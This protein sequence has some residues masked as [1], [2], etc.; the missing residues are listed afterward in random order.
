[1]S[2]DTSNTHPPWLKAMQNG[3]IG[4]ARAKAFLLDRFWVLERSVDVDGADL[5]IQ[6]R[7]THRNLLDREPPRF[8]VVQ[9][10]FFGTLG[11]AQHVQKEYIVADDGELREE[12][13]LLCHTGDEMEPRSYLL[14]ANDIH[15]DFDVSNVQGYEKYRIPYAEL[16]RAGRYEITNRKRALDRIERQLQLADFTKN[17]RFLSWTLPTAATDLDAILP[18]YSE[19]IDNWWGSIPESFRDIK[20]ASRKAMIDVE[21]IYELLRKVTSETDPLACEGYVKEIAYYCKDGYGRWGIGLPD[22]LDNNEFW[23]VCKGHRE[24]VQRLRTDGR[25][26]AFLDL[27]DAIK[28]G[29]I[30][31]LQPHVPVDPNLVHRF[32]V[33]YENDSLRFDRLKSELIDVSKFFDVAKN[34]NNSG[35]VEVDSSRY[36]KVEL[37]A[38]GQMECYWLPGRFGMLKREDGDF[39]DQFC[40]YNFSIY[41]ECGDAIYE[42]RY[43]DGDKCLM[44]TAP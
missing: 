22:N 42:A 31:F 3:A 33:S 4:E 26:D 23:S 24:K 7:L 27:R 29:V 14:G 35:H 38:P 32:T 9:V 17:R 11:T 19:P 41:G 20:E 44:E 2:E 28:Q 10:K 34:L 39:L 40:E 13:F 43:G 25:L 12:F 21:V 8:G 6:R 15:S 30:Q 37:T 36:S 1:M 16:V 18:L 5:I